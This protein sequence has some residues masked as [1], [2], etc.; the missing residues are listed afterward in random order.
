M[1]STAFG[2]PIDPAISKEDVAQGSA[3]LNVAVSCAASVYATDDP[4]TSKSP[5]LA[6]AAGAK[7]TWASITGDFNP[8]GAA[9]AEVTEATA[10]AAMKAPAVRID[11]TGVT[12]SKVSSYTWEAELQT[13]GEKGGVK[14]VVVLRKSAKPQEWCSSRGRVV[15]K[16]PIG[17]EE[18]VVKDISVAGERH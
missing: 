8:S 13:S 7:D 9:F 17:S 3:T 5:A 18:V 1:I 14:Y 15:M 6:P 11:L 12:A 4:D 16:N 10:G 2:R